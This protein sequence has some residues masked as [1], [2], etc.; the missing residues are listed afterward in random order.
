MK[1]IGDLNMHFIL[2]LTAEFIT[3]LCTG[4]KIKYK[5]SGSVRA[6]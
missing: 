4:R 5:I 6:S 1:I 2:T 3:L